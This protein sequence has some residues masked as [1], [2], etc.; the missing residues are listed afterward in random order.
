MRQTLT[1]LS[2]VS[3]GFAL[4]AQASEPISLGDVFPA[5]GV[6]SP[7]FTVERGSKG[8][9]QNRV[10]FERYTDR[11]GKFVAA[12]DATYDSGRLSAARYEQGQTGDTA[13]V[14][15]KAG[16]ILYSHTRDGKTKQSTETDSGDMVPFCAVPYVITAEWDDLRAGKAVNLTIP[17]HVRREAFAFKLTKERTWSKTGWTFTEFRLEPA[18]P[19][20]RT[21]SDPFYYI[22]DDQG[23]TLIEYRGITIAKSGTPG[24]LKDFKARVVYRPA[25]DSG[26]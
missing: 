14:E 7:L 19:V 6:G 16:K 17:I 26:K 23:K 24:S 1:I 13:M 12:V 5:M 15:I 21:L 20:F 11:D 2:I 22:F 18:N 8:T 4:R 25:A 10:F 3:L 9:D